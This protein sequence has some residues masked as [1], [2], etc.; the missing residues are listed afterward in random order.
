MLPLITILNFYE[1]C[2][3]PED[4]NAWLSCMTLSFTTPRRLNPDALGSLLRRKMAT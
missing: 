2:L 1:G 3:T 4:E